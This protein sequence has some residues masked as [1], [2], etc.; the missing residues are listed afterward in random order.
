MG[1][2]EL[3]ETSGVVPEETLTLDDNDDLDAEL[4]PEA[5]WEADNQNDEYEVERILDLRCIKR[6]PTSRRARE[7]L[8]KWKGYVDL[9]WIPLS[10]LNCGSLMYAFN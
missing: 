5:S 6:T 2:C 9:E 8:V 1:A 7:Y 10:Q 3:P 4:L